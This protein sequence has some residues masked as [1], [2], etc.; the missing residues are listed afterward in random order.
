MV[1]RGFLFAVCL[2]PMRGARNRALTDCVGIARSL[3]AVLR[4]ASL[5]YHL[6][7]SVV[8]VNSIPY[9]RPV[10][11][12]RRTRV[13]AASAA[14]CVRMRARPG[15]GD[16]AGRVSSR[17]AI[18]VEGMRASRFDPARRVRGMSCRLL[19]RLRVSLR[20]AVRHG[21]LR[22]RRSAARRAASVCGNTSREHRARTTASSPDRLSARDSA[23]RGVTSFRFHSAPAA[24]RTTTRRRVR[25]NERS[26]ARPTLSIH[27]RLA[28]A[29]TQA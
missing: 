4:A 18:G 25:S 8:R 9:D 28:H 7:T 13:R 20:A 12:P 17:D 26:R 19:R 15:R 21:R 29:R 2:M 1:R 14:R 22:C 3:R 27:Q 5:R 6:R 23:F 16:D 24:R 10:T 11:H